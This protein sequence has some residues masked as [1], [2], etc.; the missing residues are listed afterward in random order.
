MR[1]LHWIVGANLIHQIQVIQEIAKDV[2]HLTV[3]QRTPNWSAPLRN[4]KITEEEQKFI[5]D[6]HV[7]IK[8]RCDESVANFMHMPSARNVLDEA[9]EEREEFWE[10]L[11]A[12]RGF[13]KWLSN[14]KDIHTSKE[15][16]ALVSEFFAKKIRERVHDPQTAETLIPKC[17][18]FGTKRLPLESGYF[19]V[20]NQ[21]NVRLKDVKADPIVKVTKTGIKTEDEEME[22]DVLIYA[23]GFDGV[24]GS[25]TAI[26]F[27]GVDGSK[28]SEKW[29]EGPRTYLGVYVKDFP[30]MMILLGPHQMVGNIPRSIEY[31]GEWIARF[32]KHVRDNN[33]DYVECTNKSVESWTQHVFDCA[34]GLLAN[35]VDSWMTGVNKN[36]GH[37]QKRIIARYN[38]P[39]P[40]YR[41]KTKEVEENGYEGLL[42]LS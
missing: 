14:Y 21:E 5:D 16:N 24:T 18:G 23:T 9:P 20:F 15:A 30:N 36:L 31:T 32:M 3:L 35:E 6:N 26:D 12:T 22:F 28:L 11:Y 29:A 41:K 1:P 39:A 27:Q 38:G 8:H 34:Q 25:F 13:E 40:G 7:D 33:I 42:M 17:H 37:K 2:G 4:G 10:K 19:E